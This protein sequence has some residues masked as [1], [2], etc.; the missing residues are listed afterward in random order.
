MSEGK[1]SRTVGQTGAVLGTV[2]E[3]FG[4]LWAHKL[5]WAIPM[6]LLLLLLA[7]LVFMAQTTTV[8]PFIYPLF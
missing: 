6:L 2:G 8:A 3:L 4:L 7:A 1:G 5:W